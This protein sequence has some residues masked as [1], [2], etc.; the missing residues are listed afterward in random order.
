MDTIYLAQKFITLD[1]SCPIAEA[2]AVRDGRIL[3]V[4]SLSEIERYLEGTDYKVDRRFSEAVVTP[5]FIEAHGH[6]YGNGSVCDFPWVG[7]DDRVRADGTIDY[8]CTTIDAVIERLRSEV[9]RAIAEDKTLLGF[10]FDP[11]FH[12]GRSLLASDLDEVCTELGVI[13]MNASGHLC[14]ANNAQMDRNHID[15]STKDPGVMVDQAG[16]PSGIFHESAMALVLAHAKIL[17]TSPERATKNGGRLAQLAG[18]T[19]MT[20]I[21]MVTIGESFEA[22]CSTARSLGFP[23]RVVYS[24]NVN[25]LQRHMSFEQILAMAIKLRDESDEQCRLGPMKWLADGSIQGYTGKLRWP[26]YCAGEDHGFLIL[27]E[28]AIVE[29][30]TPFHNEG[31]QAAIHTNGDEATAVALRALERVLTC[32][33]RPD[34]RHRLEHC[35]LASRA[36]LAKMAALG[37]GV[38]F[39]SNHLYY[40]GDT[41]RTK[42]VG[43]DKARRMNAAKSA[44]DAGVTFSIHSDA[45]V[46]PVGPLFTMW[47]AVNRLTRSGFV[48]GEYE[49]LTAGEALE[50][51]T[52]GSARLLHLDDDLGSIEVGKLAD[53]TVLS[54]SPL[55]VEPEA[56]RDIAVLGTVLGGVVMDR[57]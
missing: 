30:V 46:T 20:D 22:F 56:I 35:Q 18:C 9:D 15:A 36:Q 23:V 3:H 10:G 34:H 41:H 28:E 47:C 33:P 2:V 38:N 21:G 27:D 19:T 25:E 17:G 13:V 5:G 26:G 31:F 52:M 50:A 11:T 40:W 4:G 7:Y 32:H 45:P 48:L 57:S 55:D 53:F 14:Y 24:P 12:D 37:I 8:G 49:R 54:A 6:L 16:Q 43:P 39:F 1:P 44:L 51:M 42:T 29:Q